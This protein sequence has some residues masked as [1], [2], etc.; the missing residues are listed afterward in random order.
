MDTFPQFVMSRPSLDPSNAERE[1]AAASNFGVGA[2]VGASSVW[3]VD[4]SPLQAEVMRRDL[5]DRHTVTVFHEA[6]AM[7]ERLSLG[8]RPDLLVLD[9]QMPGLSGL[10][11][12]RFVR[13]LLDSAELPIVIVTATG[14][15][16]DLITGL[17]AGANDFLRKPF[18]VAELN[19]RV[20]A[21]VRTKRLHAK[22]T[23]TESALRDEANFREQFLAI[24]AHDLRQPLNVFALGSETLRVPDTSQ[25]ARDRVASQLVRA[26]GRMQ[27]MIG[28]LLDFSRARPFGGM[29]IAPRTTDLAEVAREVVDEI[30]LAHPARVIDVAVAGACHG[31][32]DPDRLAQ[33]VSNLVENALA[34][35]PEGSPVSMAIGAKAGRIEV[36]VEN[37]GETIPAELLPTIFDAFRGGGAQKSA[38]TGLGLGLYIVAQIVKAHGGTVTAESGEGRTRFEVKL[39]LSNT[40]PGGEQ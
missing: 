21:L 5:A 29:P 17:T 31:T 36:V 23:A 10:D 6:D 1:A 38:R 15:H 26:A 2:S 12:C 14:E 8:E 30:R 4:D 27:R 18:D 19:A 11:A 34:H 20:A 22:L 16:E 3:L 24:L 39:P 7:L 37:F 35:S 25:E 9:W 32:W 40:E 13:G 33:V 28:E